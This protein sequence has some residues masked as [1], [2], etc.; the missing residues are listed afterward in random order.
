MAYSSD[1]GPINVPL[2]A[3]PL[4]SR[5]VGTLIEAIASLLYRALITPRVTVSLRRSHYPAGDHREIISFEKALAHY[6][7]LHNTYISRR[8]ERY[9]SL[10][11]FCFVT[12]I[13]CTLS[14]SK[15]LKP[16]VAAIRP[17]LPLDLFR[18]ARS[19]DATTGNY[20]SR[21]QISNLAYVSHRCRRKFDV[22]DDVGTLLEHKRSDQISRKERAERYHR[23]PPAFDTLFG[24]ESTKGIHE[25]RSRKA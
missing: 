18:I 5:E 17:C 16:R 14:D 23:S 12:F 6:V 1:R 9:L 11:S 20:F 22:R 4:F 10:T 21:M 8:T 19:G 3:Y 13:V 24:F 2:C 7:K 15:I 25:R